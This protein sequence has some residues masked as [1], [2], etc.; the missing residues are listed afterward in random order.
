MKSFYAVGTLILALLGSAAFA[1][2]EGSMM[3]DH[4][5]PK[6]QKMM[7]KCDKMG[8]AKAMKNKACAAMMKKHE[9]M[10][11]AMMGG[12]AMH[13]DIMAPDPMKH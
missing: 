3:A 13:P 5:S 1:M 11:G 8:H 12:D 4:M 10:G 9:M 2:P 7:T 6:A